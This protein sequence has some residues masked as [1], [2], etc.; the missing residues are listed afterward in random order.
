M[1][2]KAEVETGVFAMCDMSP[3]GYIEIA[4]LKLFRVYH[5]AFREHALRSWAQERGT[6]VN[7]ETTV[8]FMA[9]S[10]KSWRND[11]K[12]LAEEKPLRQKEERLWSWVRSHF[13]LNDEELCKLST[14]VE[15]Y[16]DSTREIVLEH[17]HSWSSSGNI[18]KE[19]ML[20]MK[21]A[22]NTLN[23]LADNYTLQ[24]KRMQEGVPQTMQLCP[25]KLV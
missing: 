7:W 5:L 16:D 6:Q 18:Q 4:L 10:N 19:I 23:V 25:I 9:L 20:S 12:L 13:E 22:Q 15:K 3:T 17:M 14:L 24:K 21:K 8:E 11:L 2:G 1:L